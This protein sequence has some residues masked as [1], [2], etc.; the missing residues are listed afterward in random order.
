MAKGL[1][2]VDV[3]REKLTSYQSKIRRRAAKIIYKKKIMELAD[4]VHEALVKELKDSR[5]WETQYYMILTL[6]KIGCVQSLPV[7]WEIVVKNEEHSTVTFGATLSWLRLSRKYDTDIT[8]IF[9]VIFWAKYSVL[10]GAM[11]WLII[12]L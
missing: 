5:T 7:L 2:S 11:Y 10:S 8:P 6:G 9:E 4:A 12:S 3:L 1:I